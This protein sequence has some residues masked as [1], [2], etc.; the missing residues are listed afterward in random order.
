MYPDRQNNVSRQLFVKHLSGKAF[1]L[2]GSLCICAQALLNAPN[3]LHLVDV[4]GYEATPGQYRVK[5]GLVFET[6]RQVREQQ[7]LF[8]A[9]AHKTAFFACTSL[10]FVVPI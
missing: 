9:S 6:P 4:I 10:I 1:Q 2:R 5:R 7:H 8:T 3:V